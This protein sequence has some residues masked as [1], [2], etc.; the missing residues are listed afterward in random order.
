MRHLATLLLVLTALGG[1]AQAPHDQ[2]SYDAWKLAT[3]PPAPNTGVTPAPDPYVQR[4]GSSTCDCW[5]MPDANYT[6]IDNNTQWDASGFHNADDGS[7]GPI[8]LPFQFYLYGTLYNTVYINING[9]VSFGQYY[10]TFS[11]TG[12]PFNGYTMVAPFWADVDLRGPGFGNNIVQFKV[13]PTAMYVNWTNVGYFSQMTDKV[14]TFQLIITDGTDPVVP[15]GA[16]VSFCYKDMQWTTGSASGGTNGFGGTPASVGANEGNG[17]DYIQFG[18][19]DQPGTAYD[20]PFGLNDGVSFLD[21]QY[22]SFSTDIT[23]ANVPPVIS[24]QSVC[25]SIILCVGDLATLD[26][27]FLSPEPNQITTPSASS[28]TLSNFTITSLVPGLAATITIDILPTPADVGFHII[29]VQGT[30]DGVPSMTSTLNIVVEVQQGALITPGSLTVCDL[31]APVDMLTLLGGNP[32]NTGDWTD[33]NG[34]VH[35]GTFDPGVDL[36]GAYLYAVG[37]GSSCA[38]SGTVTMTTQASVNAG[39][40]VALAYCT[41]DGQDDLFLNIP[42]G[43]MASGGWQYP[44]GSVFSGTLDPGVDP[45]GVYRYIVPGTSPCPNDT[46]FVTVDIPQAVDPGTDASLTL[47]SDAPLLDMLATLGG[48]PDATGQWSDPNQQPVPGTFLAATDA[49][50]VYTYTVT[51]TA[52]C[53]TLTATLTLAV[54]PLPDAGQDATLVICFDGPVTQLF[55]LLGGS[56]DT[57]GNWLDP[58]MLAHAPVLDPA[59]DSSGAYAYVAYGIGTCSLL[60]DTALVQ[61]TVNPLPVI[62]FTV[63]PDS[64]CHPLQTTLTNT[65]DPIYLGGSCVWDLGDGANTL[66]CDSVEHLYEL[67]GW[68]TVGLTITT[69]QGCTD[70]LLVP[71]AVTV[72]PAPLATFIFSPNPGTEQ[73]AS[74]YFASDDPEAVIWSW[75]F[76]GTD[77]A[78]ER[79]LYYEFS[80]VIGDDHEVCLRVTD[81]YGCTDSLCKVVPVYVPAIYIPNAFTP[82]GNNLNELFQPV[83]AD[84]VPEEHTFEVYDRWGQLIFKTNDIEQGWDGRA[85]GGGE[86]L[87][88]GVY[89]WRLIGRP[90]FAAEKQEWVGHVNLVK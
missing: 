39:Q 84:M 45:A 6:T 68:Y 28:T 62:S 87:P 46:A 63:E 7:Y 31:D 38:A 41:S 16:N 79:T 53:P 19:F 64:G 73:N 61:V 65:T 33:P 80:D 69:P 20:G 13:T 71:G 57:G 22:F 59:A 74:I 86:I 26:V 9:N 4:G 36:D 82:D 49:P 2:A 43:P 27:T 12:F 11:S 1:A 40:D 85:Q 29:S 50:G 81:Q 70:Q 60:T 67:P 75:T 51:G 17:V 52:P 88:T 14:N 48:T 77:T 44:N 78:T 23:T 47:C 89:T 25:D 66:S 35:S 90:V 58:G 24:G 54:D 18:R 76:N 37:Q 5:V 34:N 30:D 55:P 72:D 10:G 42:G 32:P 3:F 83:L 8:V 56:P 15:N 21:D